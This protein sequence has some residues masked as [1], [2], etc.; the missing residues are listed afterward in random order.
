MSL[1]TYAILFA[2]TAAFGSGWYIRGM[3]AHSDTKAAVNVAISL[4]RGACKDAMAITTK[5]GVEYETK[6][7]RLNGKLRAIRLRP[8]IC[9]PLASSTASG[10]NASAGRNQ[11]AGTHGI[12][13]GQLLEFAGDAESYRIRLISCQDFVR[14]VTK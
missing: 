12:D 11:L 7:S 10:D 13:A 3:K 9:V 2:I 1:K 4:E 14:Q 8:A 5:V 6:I